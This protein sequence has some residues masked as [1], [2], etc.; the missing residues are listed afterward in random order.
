MLIGYSVLDTQAAAKIHDGFQPSTCRAHPTWT[1]PKGG[2]RR[3]ED[4]WRHWLPAAW[5]HARW[6]LEGL[7]ARP[8]RPGAE[9]RGAEGGTRQRVQD[10][11]PGH[12][13][14]VGRG[15]PGR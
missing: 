15:Q 14:G 6:R 8:A 5:Q 13:E 3:K 7:P 2:D 1:G 9:R 11:G 10:H 12:D 4:V